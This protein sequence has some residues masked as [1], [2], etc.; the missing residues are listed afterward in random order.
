MIRVFFIAVAALVLLGTP[1]AAKDTPKSLPGVTIVSV[2]SVKAWMDD[3][4]EMFLLDARKAEEFEE[5][6]LPDAVRCPVNTDIGLGE[7]VIKKAVT[8]LERCEDLKDVPKDGLI[9]TYC[10]AYT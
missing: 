1:L 10:N 4:K 9:I 2:D 3:G 7:S 5:S 8:F 6:H